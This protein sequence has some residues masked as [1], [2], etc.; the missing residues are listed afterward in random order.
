MIQRWI[1]AACCLLALLAFASMVVA[2]SDT[3][4]IRWS[5]IDGGGT[6]VSAGE[7]YTLAATVGQPDGGATSGAVYALVGG[8]W[9]ATPVLDVAATQVYLPVVI[10]Q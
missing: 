1:T 5:T 7:A 9:G 2:Q 3:W 10:R 8:F 6:A 4:E